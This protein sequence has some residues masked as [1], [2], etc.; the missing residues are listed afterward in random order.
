[1]NKRW[2]TLRLGCQTPWR[3]WS[4]SANIQTPTVSPP[5]SWSVRLNQVNSL[6]FFCVLASDAL[7]SLEASCEMVLSWYVTSHLSATQEAS[8]PLHTLLRQ[9]AEPARP[10]SS[11]QIPNKS[12]KGMKT[13]KGGGASGAVELNLTWRWSQQLYFCCVFI[14][15]LF[16]ISKVT[17]SRFKPGMH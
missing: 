7:T 4:K 5:V 1:M 2:K 14:N 8:L 9:W 12:L 10:W 6:F 3:S 16:C 17:F 11:S 13:K 15:R